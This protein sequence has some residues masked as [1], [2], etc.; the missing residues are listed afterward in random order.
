MT[1]RDRSRQGPSTVEVFVTPAD[2]HGARAEIERR[3]TAVPDHGIPPLTAGRETDGSR[4]GRHMPAFEHAHVRST[5]LIAAPELRMLAPPA[6]GLVTSTPCRI[7]RPGRQE[8]A[9]RHFRT[10]AGCC[11]S[12][13][14]PCTDSTKDSPNWRSSFQAV[15]HVVPQVVRRCSRRQSG[16]GVGA[17][18]RGSIRHGRSSGGTTDGWTRC[19]AS[20]RPRVEGRY[21]GRQS[22]PSRPREFDS[23]GL[24]R[25]EG[26]PIRFR[27]PVQES[28]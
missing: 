26:D 3:S 15:R 7:G 14:R 18:P 10:S 8:P 11:P 13:K 20:S 4:D 5:T 19:V 25:T 6:L 22:E 2:P 23:Q 17:P 1:A 28:L 24:Q 21:Y 16:G 12:T 27:V 9:Q